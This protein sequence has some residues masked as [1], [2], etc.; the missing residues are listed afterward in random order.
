MRVGTRKAWMVGSRHTAHLLVPKHE[1]EEGEDTL[2]GCRVGRDGEDDARR[3]RPLLER[4]A[5]GAPP[6][7]HTHCS[8]S[9]SWLRTNLLS[10]G[11][12]RLDALIVILMSDMAKNVMRVTRAK[13]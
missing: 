2:T 9:R 7:Q 8:L 3:E 5:V 11:V 4:T 13:R 6:H 1:L 12:S 10:T